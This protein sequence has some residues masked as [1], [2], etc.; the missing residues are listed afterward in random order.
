MTIPQPK[1]YP[2]LL[3]VRKRKNLDLRPSAFLRETYHDPYTGEDLAFRLRDYQTIGAFHLLQ[4]RRFVLGD[5]T[6][7]GKTI[8]AISALARVW[9]REDA[10]TVIITTKSSRRQWREEFL[11][12]TTLRADEILLVDGTP[13]ARYSIYGAFGA[14]K[15]RV[16]ILNY[17]LVLRDYRQ[18]LAALKDKRFVLILDEVA[19]VKNHRAQ[20]HKVIS[21]VSQAAD[22]VWGMTATLLKNRL[23]EGFGIYRVV[24]PGLFD[25]HAAFLRDFCVTKLQR[26]GPRRQ[27][28]IV[29]GHT[30]AQV[31]RFRATIDPYFL[32]RNKRDVVDDLPVLITRVIECP[33]ETDQA[34]VYVDALQGA[35]AVEDG[36]EEVTPLAALTRC[37]QIADSAALIQ[38]ISC[39]SSPKV[40]TLV[41]LLTGD[42]EGQK[43]IVFSRF[44]SMVTLMAAELTRAGRTVGRITGD[45]S[46]KERAATQAS[47]Q[48]ADGAVDTILMTTAGTEALNLQAASAMVFVDTPWSHGDYIQAIGRMVRIGSPHRGVLV[49]H[50]VATIPPN[51]GTRLAEKVM[52]G[53]ETGLPTID[54]LVLQKQRVKKRLI[55]AAVGKGDSSVL[56]LKSGESL[57]DLYNDLVAGF[58][59]ARRL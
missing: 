39:K 24:V 19:A 49:Y 42:L 50:L 13:E 17:H 15:G 10:R 45:E 29:V 27:I 37:Q 54:H 1:V 20:T 2:D 46:E 28:P 36:I 5:D 26:I 9:E 25:T 38:G 22:R 53:K 12:F 58:R 59:A 35:I 57:R 23:E 31:Q 3:D 43:V 14:G 44:S 33:M 51:V 47:F 18:L 34:Q 30:A 41:D 16:L 7:V 11:R 40:E 56:D 48:S 55:D 4:M 32:G 8:E 52:A 6:G 21:L